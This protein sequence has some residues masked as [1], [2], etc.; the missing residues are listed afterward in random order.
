MRFNTPLMATLFIAAICVIIFFFESYN[1][2]GEEELGVKT[3]MVGQEPWR[4]FTFM[5]THDGSQHLFMNLLAL[6]LV[7]FLALELG[8]RGSTF[9]AIFMVAGLLTIAPFLLVEGSYNLVGASAGICGLFG[10]VAVEFRRYGFSPLLI[11]LLFFL[12]LV[13]APVTEVLSGSSGAMTGA[14]VHSFALIL[15]AGLALSF[16]SLMESPAPSRFPDLS[17]LSGGGCS[18]RNSHDLDRRAK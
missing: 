11:F 16:R 18:A 2:I 14:F 10:A 6:V 7:G 4:L 1:Y 3:S 9:L 15:G 13:A 8:I 12:G 5:F 17:R